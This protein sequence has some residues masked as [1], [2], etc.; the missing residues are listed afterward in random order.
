MGLGSEGGVQR[1][2]RGGLSGMGCAASLRLLLGGAASQPRSLPAPPAW[3]LPAAP[4]VGGVTAQPAWPRHVAPGDGISNSVFLTLLSRG[5][6]FCGR[7]SKGALLTP[8]GNHDVM[9][10]GRGRPK[11]PNTWREVGDFFF[12]FHFLSYFWLQTHCLT[13]LLISK[14]M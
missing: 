2:G 10:M 7:A 8:L 14:S 3:G 4:V 11:P 13:C 1:W 12:F 6:G 9:E 5:C